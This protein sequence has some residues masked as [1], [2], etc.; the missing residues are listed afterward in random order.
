MATN[1]DAA[2]PK[3]KQR[4]CPK[5][6]K[7]T[8][9]RGEMHELCFDCLD[10]GP[11][12]IL[13]LRCDICRLWP[14]K[15]FLA[16][17]AKYAEGSSARQEAFDLGERD[18]DGDL[19]SPNNVPEEPM[20][21]QEK[22]QEQEPSTSDPIPSPTP[23]PPPPGFVTLA[24]A[25]LQ[26]N[27][28]AVLQQVGLV[29]PIGELGGKRK[30]SGPKAKGSS[31][32]SRSAKKP[33]KKEN[34]FPSSVRELDPTAG[35]S[36][37]ASEGHSGSQTGAGRASISTDAYEEANRPSL[38][39]RPRT[40]ESWSFTQGKSN[41]VR[42]SESIDFPTPW[43]LAAETRGRETIDDAHL[44]TTRDRIPT[45]LLGAANMPGISPLIH[46]RVSGN[47][48][49]RAPTLRGTTT[50]GINY[51]SIDGNA[52]RAT[53][54]RSGTSR[55]SAED[56]RL[57]SDMEL[58]TQEVGQ[59]KSNFRWAVEE[60]ATL[61]GLPPPV[62]QPT[63]GTGRFATVPTQALIS[64]PMADAM[65]KQCAAI[66]NCVTAKKDVGRSEPAFPSIALK[67]R[68]LKTYSS[69]VTNGFTTAT[70]DEDDAIGLLS[71]KKAVWSA[72][73]KK[74]RLHSWQTMAHHVMGQLSSGDHF[75]K[76]VQEIIDDAAL[77]EQLDERANA[78]LSVLHATL[79]GAERV[80]TT[81][82]AH[83]DLTAREADLRLLDL[84]ETDMTELRARPLFEGH[85]FGGIQRSTAL[86]MRSNRK[87]EALMS[88]LTKTKAP[89]KAKPKSGQ[90]TTTNTSGDPT[91]QSQPFR[92]NP[93][94]SI[95]RRGGKSKGK[96][97]S[98]PQDKSQ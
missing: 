63:V 12:S 87:D 51:P 13:D 25:D 92:T 80:I 69:S 23:P 83:L 5:C 67:A 29:P 85:T 18:Q 41:T 61:M 48:A 91:R 79:Q 57:E 44:G 54:S 45:G 26:A 38:V 9:R 42:S 64:L 4:P 98:K 81:L 89:P 58:D 53:D 84:S 1:T 97:R 55:A 31:S 40:S 32:S 43:S 95:S 21:I 77:P 10:H 74:S 72:Q 34:D 62:H 22:E 6:N 46:G 70:P 24:P 90:K 52:S 17:T 59:A 49:G 20:D 65:L 50:E 73:L 7:N 36:L 15:T 30:N 3:S 47:A 8:L 93:P 14:A 96:G 88:H 94:P 39:A 82:T 27:I 86:E 66:N 60:C 35:S 71:K 19:E 16:A 76:L 33:K 78:A 75:T 56:D 28:L 37:S 68:S 2:G 11:M